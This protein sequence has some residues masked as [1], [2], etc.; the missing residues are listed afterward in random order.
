MWIIEYSEDEVVSGGGGSRPLYCELT[1]ILPV[2]YHCVL[3]IILRLTDSEDDWKSG[4]KMTAAEW[5][6]AKH[7]S[8]IKAC[9]M[10]SRNFIHVIDRVYCEGLY[11]LG[12]V[13]PLALSTQR[14][15]IGLGHGATK[16]IYIIFSIHT[17]LNFSMV[18]KINL[19]KTIEEKV[20]W[21]ASSQEAREWSIRQIE[22]C[23]W[24]ELGPV[25]VDII[26][27]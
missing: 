27:K 6:M 25:W 9:L 12:M 3:P 11:F 16:V 19:E 13:E 15:R 1:F 8:H 7:L 20:E 4:K 21:I 17:S 22:N 26:D 23:S 24:M 5:M 2:C 10:L 18:N 14:G